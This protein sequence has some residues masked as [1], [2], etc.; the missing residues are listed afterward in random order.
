MLDSSGLVRC[1]TPQ[2]GDRSQP[3]ASPD[4][5][6]APPWVI[7]HTK[8]PALKGRQTSARRTALA[9][10]YLCS[11]VRNVARTL[12]PLQGR[13]VFSCKPTQGCPRQMAQLPWAMLSRPFR[14]PDPKAASVKG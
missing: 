4:S 5:P 12:Q 3:R 13:R 8:L 10:R 9:Y 11:K 6:G 14:A 2:R 1:R 7:S